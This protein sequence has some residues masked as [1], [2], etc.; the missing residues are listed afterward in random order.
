MHGNGYIP[1]PNKYKAML[2]QF[3]LIFPQFADRVHKWKRNDTE[4]IEI[5][6][7]NH[8]VM[9]FEHHGDDWALST[10]GAYYRYK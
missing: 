9:I 4:S 8:K 2:D 7:D 5:T 3:K 1:S 10:Q 6:L